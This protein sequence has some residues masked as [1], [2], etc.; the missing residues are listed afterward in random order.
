MIKKNYI[1]KDL[2]SPKYK[3]RIVKDK[4]KYTRKTKHTLQINKDKV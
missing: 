2:H 3:Q 4:S 1:A